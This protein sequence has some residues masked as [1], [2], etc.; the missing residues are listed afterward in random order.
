MSTIEDARLNVGPWLFIIL[1]SVCSANQG[2]AFSSSDQTDI[3]ESGKC[4][5]ANS[6][7]LK[8]ASW[9]IR[10]HDY[11]TRL[12]AAAFD[13]FVLMVKEID[14]DIIAFQ[15]VTAKADEIVE[16]TAALR[17]DTRCYKAAVTAERQGGTYAVLYDTNTVDLAY[18]A[19]AET[20]CAAGA[21]QIIHDAPLMKSAPGS[22]VTIAASHLSYFRVKSSSGQSPQRFDFA[23]INVNVDKKDLDSF[24]QDFQ[25]LDKNYDWLSNE[26]DRI[27]VGDLGIAAT[28]GQL[29]GNYFPQMK[30]LINPLLLI[31]LGLSDLSFDEAVAG[32]RAS[33]RTTSGKVA[34]QSFDN[35]LVRR[36]DRPGTCSLQKYCGGLE[37]FINARVYRYDKVLVNPAADFEQSVSDRNP[38]AARFCKFADTDPDVGTI[39]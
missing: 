11:Q 12:E 37:E 25:N 20:G 32:S 22:A 4:S 36:W 35:I 1:I 29:R 31:N 3:D 28:P 21:A 30:P 5:I 33:T 39:P 38:V 15:E 17:T 2:H 16:L 26:Q 27:V 24:V 14:A 18:P 34:G 23:L 13:D 19:G 10:D 9:N 8:I 6:E 7:T